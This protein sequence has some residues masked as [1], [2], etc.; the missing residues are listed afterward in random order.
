MTAVLVTGGAGYI[1]SHAAKALAEAG[2]TPVVYDDLSL[3]H[4]DFVRWGPFVQ[5]DI[6]DAKTVEDACRT[7]GVAAVMHFAAASLV[8]ESLV[9]PAKY[10]RNNTAGA[11]GLLDGMRAAGVGTIV[12]SSTAATYGQPDAALIPEDA[13]QAPINPYGASKLMVERILRDYGEAYGLKWTALRYFN[14]CGADESAEIGE[15]RDP[16][17]HLIP[18]ALM[19]LQGW[20]KDFA[21]FGADYPTPDGT[22]IRDYIHV[23]DLAEAHV[24]ALR[25]LLDGGASAAFNLGVGQGYSVRQVLDAIARVTGHEIPVQDAPRRP[26]DPAVLVAD[27]SKAM[28]ELGFRATRSDLDRI[29]ASAWAWHLRAHPRKNA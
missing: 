9:D 15:K 10:Y 21:V 26:G 5:G 24:L 7:H 16:E 6:A 3:G 19:A 2:F 20:V 1:G 27:P 25:R 28:R 8:G 22:A 11:L 18:R 17:T 4:R 14:A 29:V 23:D 13:P 12:F